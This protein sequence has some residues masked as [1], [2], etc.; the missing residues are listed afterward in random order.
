MIINQERSSKGRRKWWELKVYK[1]L[2][3]GGPGREEEF[4]M[5]DVGCWMWRGGGMS[6]KYVAFYSDNHEHETFETFNQAKKWLEEGYAE[7]LPEEA[8]RDFIAKITHRAKFVETDNKKNY[9]CL[10][11]P[12]ELAE[13]S[14]CEKLDEYCDGTEEWPYDSDWDYVGKIEFEE[15]GK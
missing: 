5:F 2:K 9:P 11:R 8:S 6:D 3:L 12:L 15:V 1:V 4:W 14:G 13:C 10:R 7:G